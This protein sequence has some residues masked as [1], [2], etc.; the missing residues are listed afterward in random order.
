MAVKEVLDKQTK[1]NKY[2]K[3]VFDRNVIV[4]DMEN[5]HKAFSMRLKQRDSYHQPIYETTIYAEKVMFARDR[6][7][8]I[9]QDI[10][11]TLIITFPQYSNFRKAQGE[12]TLIYSNAAGVIYGPMPKDALPSF[13]M[14]FLPVN[15]DQY[16]NFDCIETLGYKTSMGSFTT[17]TPV[18]VK[19]GYIQVETLGYKTR[20]SISQFISKL[21]GS[22]TPGT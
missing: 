5:L 19:E 22:I 3:L 12:V 18:T 2:V 7:D 15:I 4:N 20:N 10:T 17:F 6:D 11:N 13:E 21:V 9:W 1:F 14:K 8:V 16:Q